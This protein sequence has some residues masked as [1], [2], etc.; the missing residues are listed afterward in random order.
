MNYSLN[1]SGNTRRS[2]LLA[3]VIAGH[4]GLF[5]LILT[6][7]T[8]APQIMEMPLIVDLIELAPVVRNEPAAKPLPVA[9]PAPPAP[10]PRSQPQH[11]APTNQSPALETTSST[12]PVD[13]APASPSGET[14]T[15]TSAP[16]PAA[17]HSGESVSQA[18]FDADYLRNPAP[19]YP[20][21]SRRLGE[22]GK[23]ILR[24]RV[25]PEGTAGNVE[26]RTS[27]GSQRLDDSALRTV[28]NWKFIPAKRGTTPVESWVLVPIIF[29]L[30]Q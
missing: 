27:S 6:A 9:R 15:T 24:V 8:V 29:K 23:V 7:R 12:V 14:K 19:P 1:H 5:T 4:I 18:S 17:A 3:T 20:Q 13:N 26:V 21:M 10:K 25:L 30:E 2:G 22:E 16:S 28:K 11:S